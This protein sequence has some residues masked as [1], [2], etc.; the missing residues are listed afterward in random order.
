MAAATIV[1]LILLA[2]LIGI[3]VG[4][5]L[6]SDGKIKD[7]SQKNQLIPFSGILTPPSPPW[8]VS[9]SS[10]NTGV[11]HEPEDGL[12]LLGMKGGESATVPQIQCPE[13]SSINIV[14][15]FFDVNDPYGE[16]SNTPNSTLRMTCGDGTDLTSAPTCTMGDDSTCPPG[17]T[18]YSGKCIP[19]TCSTSADCTG[20]GVMR[21]C[22]ATIGATCSSQSDCGSGAV[23]MGGVCQV[24]PGAGPCMTCGEGGTCLTLPTCSNVKA[25]LNS[26]CSPSAGDSHRCR[27]RDASAWLAAECDGKQECIAT[28]GKNWL[29]NQK[30][31]AFGPLP[32]FIPAKSGDS[33]YAGLPIVQGWGGGT[34]AASADGVAAPATFGQGYKVHGIYTCILDKE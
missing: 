23:C 20:G 8:T 25:G 7:L 18:C 10:N 32:C 21:A 1:I 5:G 28:T 27:P 4:L 3:F 11:G 29:P 33:T 15:A 9:I 19:A 24:D 26:T 2:I 16:C 6:W 14:G 12:L 30:G 31:G 22:P 13:G 17:M 34:P